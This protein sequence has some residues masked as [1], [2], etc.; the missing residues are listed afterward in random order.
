MDVVSLAG[1]QL[2][3]QYL[4]AISETNT[5]VMQTGSAGIFG[6]GFPANR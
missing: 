3:D 2:Q 6:L 4:A 5:K 1:L